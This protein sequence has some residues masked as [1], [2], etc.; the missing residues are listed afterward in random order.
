MDLTPARI[1]LRIDTLVLDGLDGVDA[2]AVGTAVRRELARLLSEGGVPPAWQQG[3]T[4]ARLD[5]GAV[6]VAPGTPSGEVG[7]RI[8]RTLYGEPKP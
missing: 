6:T 7:A 4:A 1:D 2:A 8:A 5:G 3:G